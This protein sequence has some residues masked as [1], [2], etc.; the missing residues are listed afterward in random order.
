M[1]KL[2]IWSQKDYKFTIVSILFLKG[3]TYL[4]FFRLFELLIRRKKD[5]NYFN[6]VIDRL[7]FVLLFELLIRS[8]KDY[9]CF[10]LVPERLYTSE[11][12]LF[13]FQSDF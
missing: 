4:K 8:K 10:N 9:N 5:Y 1:N 13:I 2:L 12:C 3:C 6:L 7:N 11:L